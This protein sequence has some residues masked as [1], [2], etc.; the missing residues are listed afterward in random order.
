M[1]YSQSHRGGCVECLIRRR[2]HLFQKGSW[3]I[4]TGHTGHTL[5]SVPGKH[6][7]HLYVGHFSPAGHC[8]TTPA[9]EWM[10][11][12][13]VLVHLGV[14]HPMRV[15]R[16]LR[17][18]R[19]DW[20]EI[21]HTHRYKHAFSCVSHM[22]FIVAEG[23]VSIQRLRRCRILRRRYKLHL[24]FVSGDSNSDMYI[25]SVHIDIIQV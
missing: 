21:F 4:D 10:A 16:W 3:I 12:G 18:S 22:L 20:V 6:T 1:L 5:H 2:V 15:R 19:D 8:H 7:A 23:S 25:Y 11:D 17:S 13:F 24:E 14:Y 9:A